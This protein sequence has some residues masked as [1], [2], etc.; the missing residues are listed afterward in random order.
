MDL[1]ITK[2]YKMLSKINLK[3]CDHIKTE[4]YIKLLN[5]IYNDIEMEND[6]KIYD[7]GF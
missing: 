6:I 2:I 5:K 1:Y 3:I 4:K 7:L